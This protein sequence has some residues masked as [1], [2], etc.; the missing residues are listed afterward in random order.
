MKIALLVGINYANDPSITLR[1]CINDIINIR[2]MLIDAYDYDSNNIIML[3]DDYSNFNPPTREIILHQLTAIAAESQNLEE[4]W[5][6]YSGHGS[7]LQ[8]QNSKTMCD[9]LI[10]V[11][12]RETSSILD[13]E[14]L[15]ILQIIKCRCIM[16]FDCCHSGTICDMPYSFEYTNDNNYTMTQI[17]TI[18]IANPEIYVFS[19]CRDSQSSSDTHSSMDQSVGAFTNTFIECLRNSHHNISVFELY[20]NICQKLVANG[21]SQNPVLSSS[22]KMPIFIL[23]KVMNKDSKSVFQ[24]NIQTLLQQSMRNIVKLN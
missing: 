16:V 22:T 19:G 14:L 9:I 10:P 3:R 15:S 20:K 5:F 11:D 12:Y 24:P 13:S 18:R 1:G 2:N 23:Q 7:Q 6:H 17:N 8:N 4:F 21:Y